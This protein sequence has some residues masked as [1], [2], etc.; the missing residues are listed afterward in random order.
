[1]FDPQ[2]WSASRLTVVVLGAL[3]LAALWSSHHTTQAS[4]VP[5]MRPNVRAQVLDVQC[6]SGNVGSS[7]AK[8]L[9]IDTFDV[10][11]ADSLLEITFEGR[12]DV[13]SMTGNGV[14]FELRVDDAPSPYGLARA[15]VRSD[16]VGNAGGIHASFTGMF[17][18]LAEGEHTLSLWAQA[19]NNG[20]AT[21]VR[22]DPGCFSTDHVVIK[23]YLPFGTLAL[24]FITRE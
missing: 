19:T 15:L 4:A 16:E 5:T 11:S 6:G 13:D 9:D 7:F 2:R 22:V 10:Q 23:E 21:G 8:V 14:R 12:I 18:S 1:M 24:P 17:D 20:T 3:L